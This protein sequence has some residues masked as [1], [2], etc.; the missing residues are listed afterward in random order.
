[1]RWAPENA[2]NDATLARL[3]ELAGGAE[4]QARALKLRQRATLLEP[5]NA[6]FWLERAMSEDE[7]GMAESAG[8]DFLR[9]RELFPLSPDV[10]RALGEYFLRQGRIDDALDALRF[11]IAADPEM[12]PALFGESTT[13]N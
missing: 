11:A 10:N 12:R 9:A 1:M 3:D 8:P 13:T 7:A 4:G 2:A 6:I 5:G